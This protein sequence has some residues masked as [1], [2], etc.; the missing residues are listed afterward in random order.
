[1]VGILNTLL[2]AAVYYYGLRL[3]P[4]FYLLDFTLSWITGVVFSYCLNSLWVFR[5]QQRLLSQRHFAK[6]V[7]VYLCSMSVNMLAL[8]WGVDV[9][10]FDAWYWQL[11]LIPLIVVINFSLIKFWVFKGENRD[12]LS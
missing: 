3:Y 10:H 12:S 7:S 2:T 9:W 6:Y 5:P 8:Y 4:A 1:M 11:A